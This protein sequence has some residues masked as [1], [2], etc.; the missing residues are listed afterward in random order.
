M[1]NDALGVASM[2]SISSD[3][4]F[5]VSMGARNNRQSS[6]KFKTAYAAAAA[7]F[8][9]PRA[10]APSDQLNDLKRVKQITPGEGDIY[11]FAPFFSLFLR[12]WGI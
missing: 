5:G 11:D 4:F 3:F 9:L 8:L 10:S 7:V 1:N 6:R 2:N 12:K